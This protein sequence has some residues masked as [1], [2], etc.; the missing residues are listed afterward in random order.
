MRF[1]LN[2]WVSLAKKGNFVTAICSFFAFFNDI[3]CICLRI[4]LFL[5]TIITFDTIDEAH[6]IYKF[7][8][9]WQTRHRWSV[10]LKYAMFVNKLSYER[11]TKNRIEIFCIERTDIKYNN[12]VSVSHFLKESLVTFLL[13][14]LQTGI[15]AFYKLNRILGALVSVDFVFESQSN[16]CE[17]QS[18]DGC[19]GAW[20][21]LNR[22]REYLWN[23]MNSSTISSYHLRKLLINLS[24]RKW[25]YQIGSAN[26]MN[27]DYQ[28]N[29]MSGVFKID[30][31]I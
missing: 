25:L 4:I 27:F 2:N 16:V 11:W 17:H 18:E 1:Y 9:N 28:F 29:R 21:A 3:F 19:E 30:S 5:V 7:E 22:N 31:F 10:I 23:N 8:R 6:M 26:W 14:L 20:I 13:L 15:F 24:K 12:Q